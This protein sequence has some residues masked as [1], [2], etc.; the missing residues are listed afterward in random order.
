TPGFNFEVPLLNPQISPLD[1]GVTHLHVG[2]NRRG[3]LLI[4]GGGVITTPEVLQG[5]GVIRVEG[6]GSRLIADNDL[7]VAPFISGLPDFNAELHISQGGVV[8]AKNVRLVGT[9]N[10]TVTAT[11]EGVGSQLN[12]TGLEFIVGQASASTVTLNV[13][14]GASISANELTIG[15]TDSQSGSTA[16]VFVDGPG[17]VV[18]TARLNVGTVTQ[19]GRGDL[20]IRNGA[21]VE[22]DT[23]ILNVF[24]Q[25]DG[26]RRVTGAVYVTDGGTLHI[27]GDF[28][29]FSDAVQFA[30][31]T[32]SFGG[33]HVYDSLSSNSNS[34]AGILGARNGLLSN[35]ETLKIEGNLNV[36]SGITID[37]GT[38]SAGTI[39]N[40]AGVDL[41]RGTLELTE[42]DVRVTAVGQF[43]DTLQ[44]H[45]DQ[46]LS[47][48]KQVHVESDGRV[49]LDRGRLDTRLLLN[50][51]LV[52]GTGRV[53]GAL[54]NMLGG[55]V[56]L[57][58][59]D[60]I[61]FSGPSNLNQGAINLLNA[62]HLE[63]DSEFTN[64]G[65][66]VVSGRGTVSAGGGVSNEG[67]FRFSGGASDVLG[68]VDNG[69]SIDIAG[70]GVVTFFDD[71]VSSGQFDISVGSKAVFF[72]DVA[73]D[74]TST[75]S[76]EL[77]GEADPRLNIFGEAMLGGDLALSLAGGFQPE[78]GD[79]FPIADVLSGASGAFNN[80]F[81]PVFAGGLTFE[82]NVLSS[83]VELEVVQA[84]PGAPGDF[85][86]D[87][88]VD[89]SDFLKWQR[90]GHT[91][92]GLANWQSNYGLGSPTQVNTATIPEP[93][94]AT[95]WAIGLAA[96]AVRFRAT[97]GV[98]DVTEIEII[99]L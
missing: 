72:G 62:A 25:N 23:F 26:A 38:L 3:E 59:G 98:T 71:V 67:K 56:R 18:T 53:D 79:R 68:E 86:L 76:I 84:A 28:S 46:R 48:T 39:S 1:L 42:T 13:L 41:V 64:S 89:G 9:A 57:A 4:T 61:R 83:L 60:A 80:V 34:L 54:L 27:N 70:G 8:S 6:A 47:I 20:Y 36:L 99:G 52:T 69:G 24:Q 11:V 32:V 17:S 14:S 81:A 30:G 45:A 49:E 51:G 44:L 90:E 65:T 29:L 5:D 10:D 75:L 7:V 31:G 22:A 94:T 77:N 58:G 66:G 74:A 63:F 55:E 43:G 12:S 88:D 95:L 19:S 78:L 97:A 40:L 87:G 92:S 37:R 93:G 91:P 2:T 16:K 73:L 82:V 35:N 15:A 50:R 96:L 33:D 85:D 21:R